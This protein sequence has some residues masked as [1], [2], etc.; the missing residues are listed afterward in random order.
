M[1]S[2]VRGAVARLLRS[3]KE[4]AMKFEVAPLS[5]RVLTGWP[6]NLPCSMMQGDPTSL[7][8]MTE[9]DEKVKPSDGVA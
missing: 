5:I 7:A 3:T 4:E 9:A 8:Q 1:A 2:G 6:F